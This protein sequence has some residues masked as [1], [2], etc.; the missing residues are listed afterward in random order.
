MF[1]LKQINCIKHYK[2]DGRLYYRTNKI[3]EHITYTTLQ[4]M[5]SHY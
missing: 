3:L 2:I 5:K 1:I 4:L